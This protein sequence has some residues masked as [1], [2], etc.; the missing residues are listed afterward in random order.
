MEKCTFCVQRLNRA[1]R[2]TDRLG[3]PLQDGEVLPACAQACPTNTLIF[4]N[5]NDPN[6]RIRQLAESS[7]AYHLLDHYGTEPSVVY[8]KK[9]DPTLP[10]ES[11]PGLHAGDD[12][13]A[14]D[15]AS[16]APL[17]PTG[18]QRRAAL[19][20]LVRREVEGRWLGS[21]G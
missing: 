8:L 10:D 2:A 3:R 17:S 5:W 9:V 13:P 1:R 19:A 16:T 12:Q 4:G 11:Q 6:S 18:A 14:A 15:L 20:R 21:R 7:R